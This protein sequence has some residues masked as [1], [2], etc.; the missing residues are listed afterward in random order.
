MLLPELIVSEQ[1]N[2]A[3]LMERRINQNTSETDGELSRGSL[4]KSLES[5]SEDQGVIE[6]RTGLKFPSF[7][8]PIWSTKGSD[9]S[10]QVLWIVFLVNY[11]SKIYMY[12]LGFRFRVWGLAFRV[13][14]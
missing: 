14:L 10:M 6:P 12:T 11:I 7:V 13:K 9:H 2:S 4:I 3:S 8:T 1:R 5:N